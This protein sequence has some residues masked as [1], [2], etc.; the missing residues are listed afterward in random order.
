[1]ATWENPRPEAEVQSIDLSLKS[2][3]VYPI[4]LG[5]TVEEA[6]PGSAEF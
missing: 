3:D 4:V 5:I 6:E 2:N 1:M